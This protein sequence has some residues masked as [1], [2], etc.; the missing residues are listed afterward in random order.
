V[1]EEAAASMNIYSEIPSSASQSGG[2]AT[3]MDR[4]FRTT[5]E[6]GRGGQAAGEE[7]EGLGKT[8]AV[9]PEEALY[10]Q[11]V[12]QPNLYSSCNYL[13]CPLIV[14]VIVSTKRSIRHQKFP[15]D[16]LCKT[17]NS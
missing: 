9:P 2:G 1:P 17:Y 11:P 15:Q 3:A 10:E 4:E 5:R 14:V 8:A 12:G 13:N 6:P 16:C 7:R